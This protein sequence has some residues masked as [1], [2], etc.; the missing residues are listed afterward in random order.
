MKKVKSM[1][2]MA[3]L[4]SGVGAAAENP[5]WLRNAAISPDGKTVAFTYKGDIFTVP[6]T[7]G[8]ARQLTT[9]K[10]Y[11]SAPMWAP[12]GKRIVFT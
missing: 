10:E 9:S 6:V 2:L 7:G 4:V 8:Q 5:L 12:D 1:V 11:D 3:A